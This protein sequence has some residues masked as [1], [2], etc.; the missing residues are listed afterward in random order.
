MNR[1]N[2]FKLGALI[3]SLVIA[4]K[5]VAAPVV[6]PTFTPLDK[7]LTVNNSALLIVVRPMIWGFQIRSRDSNLEVTKQIGFKFVRVAMPTRYSFDGVSPIPIPSVSMIT[8][9]DSVYQ[10]CEDTQQVIKNRCGFLE[11]SVFLPIIPE[12]VTRGP[13]LNIH[14]FRMLH[15]PYYFARKTEGPQLTRNQLL[16]KAGRLIYI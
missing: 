15:D 3:P 5:L 9:Y 2:F 16:V 4:D 10:Y 1:R 12:S 7:K 8:R 14:E 11:P 6:K 13:V